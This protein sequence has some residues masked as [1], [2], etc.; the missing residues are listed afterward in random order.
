VNKGRDKG[1]RIKPPGNPRH[2]FKL[3]IANKH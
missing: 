3:R 1:Y 2:H